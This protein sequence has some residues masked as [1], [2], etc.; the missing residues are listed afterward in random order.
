MIGFIDVDPL[1]ILK[2]SAVRYI[3]IINLDHCNAFSSE[4]IFHYVK[5]GFQLKK[6]CLQD[7]PSLGGIIQLFQYPSPT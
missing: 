3:I 4:N 7:P 1:K 5:S 6:N 2:R